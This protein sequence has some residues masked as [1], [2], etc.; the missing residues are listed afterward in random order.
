MTACTAPLVIPTLHLGDLIRLGGG[1][2]SAWSSPELT[3]DFKCASGT[4]CKLTSAAAATDRAVAAECARLSRPE[5]VQRF[6][7]C[8]AGLERQSAANPQPICETV[9]GTDVLC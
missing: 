5:C 3:L 4:D 7:C 1:Y 2:V 8:Q 9:W 6:S